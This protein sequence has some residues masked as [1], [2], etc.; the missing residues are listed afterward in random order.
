MSAI[1]M[2]KRR[3]MSSSTSYQRIDDS[4]VTIR[5]C[6]PNHLMLFVFLIM[7]LSAGAFYYAFTEWTKDHSDRMRIHTEQREYRV[8]R[9]NSLKAKRVVDIHEG[10]QAMV[11]MMKEQAEAFVFNDSSPVAEPVIALWEQYNATIHAVNDSCVAKVNELTAIV[12]QLIEGTNSTPTNVF[13]GVCEFTGND[14]NFTEFTGF[15]HNRITI[16]GVDFFY[17]VFG[18]TNDTIPTGAEGAKIENCS[19]P[20]FIG[21][22]TSGTVFRSQITGL[23]G[24]PAA[25]V[26][27]ISTIT[28]GNRELVFVPVAGASPMQEL[29]IASDITVFVSFF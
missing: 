1:Q 28:V 17:Y 13:T 3:Q 20:I 29:G 11:D 24:S 25:P 2:R 5:A 7:A 8:A 19:P 26:D 4:K 10:Q 18:A 12:T 27:Y 15:T 22:P 21:G 6:N 16:G 23:T 9:D 14:A